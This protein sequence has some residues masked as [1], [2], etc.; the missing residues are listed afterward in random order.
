MV[1]FYTS[2]YHLM[3]NCWKKYASERPHFNETCTI[4]SNFLEHLNR[5]PES[6]YESSDED[7][8]GKGSSRPSRQA[9][10]RSG[11]DNQ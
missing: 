6:M 11:E 4:L 7:E 10:I 3:Q 1:I 8:D 2:R 9:S 5:R